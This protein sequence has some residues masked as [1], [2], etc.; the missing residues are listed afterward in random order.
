MD[1][2]FIL[3]DFAY[4]LKL[5]K[6]KQRIAAEVTIVEDRNTERQAST[7]ELISAS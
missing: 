3:M 1:L 2:V 6:P 5:G 7:N 4:L